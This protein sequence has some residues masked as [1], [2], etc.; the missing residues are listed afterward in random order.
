MVLGWRHR[1]QLHQHRHRTRSRRRH[2]SRPGRYRPTIHN[3]QRRLLPLPGS[4]SGRH[5]SVLGNL[6]D[7]AAGPI[8]NHHH[9][10]QPART[11]PRPHR[12]N[13]HQGRP[14][15]LYRHHRHRRLGMGPQR[16]GPAGHRYQ[17]R[18]QQRC[19]HPRTHTGTRGD[20]RGV[21][22]YQRRRQHDGRAHT[23]HRF[24][25]RSICVRK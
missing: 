13:R 8:P 3:R 5:R 11:G 21:R 20:T 12:S 2:R 9:T 14:Q 24:Q 23:D 6:V 18:I 22:V 7:Q 17:Q 19:R 10:R 15:V 16:P 25:R 4:C 1:Q